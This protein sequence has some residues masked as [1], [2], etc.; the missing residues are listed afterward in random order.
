MPSTVNVHKAKANF[1]SVMGECVMRRNRVIFTL[2]ALCAALIAQGV[3]TQPPIDGARKKCISFGWEYGYLTPAQL[4]ANAEKFKGTAIDGVGIYLM[5]TNRAGQQIGTRNFTSGPEWD[6]EAFADQI[7]TL[8]K[9]AQTDHLRESFLKCFDAPRKRLAWTDD[10]AWARV[11]RNMGIVG[12]ISRAT[13]IKG[14]NSD[15]EDYYNQKQYQPIPGEPPY[16]EL[17]KIVR[18]RGRE[19]FGPLFREQPE[20]RVLFYW[21][22]TFDKT[23]FAVPDPRALAREKQ[24]LWPAFAD[25]IMDVLPPTARI[26]DGDEHAYNS[27]YATRDFHVSVC[28]QRQFAPR[29]LSPENRQK[30]ATQVQVGFG[31]YLDM[32]VNPGPAWYMGPVAGSRVEHFRRNYADAFKLAD[33]YVWLWGER[34]PTVHW[35]NATIN[36]SVKEK[37]TW[38]EALPGLYQPMLA[39]HDAD[40]GFRRRKDELAAKGTL[41]DL[42]SNP[43][44]RPDAESAKGKLPTPY[45]I[46]AGKGKPVFRLAEGQGDGDRHCL[47]VSGS[48]TGA[49]L[50][51]FNN[52][53]VGAAYAVSCRMKGG[54]PK[55][56][57]GWR[58]SENKWLWGLGTIR[59][60]FSPPDASGWRSG[61]AFVN[62]PMG[63]A[64]FAFVFDPKMADGETVLIDNAH[65]WELW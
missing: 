57:V 3:P 47:S 1:S 41:K 43:E 42:N 37:R 6:F 20:A 16:D 44:C 32:Y 59:L 22:L 14:F 29:L 40:Y 25:G 30:H 52:A 27:D 65:V 12:R 64:G 55:A 50:L 24:D 4:L 15:P 31:L 13:G 54:D 46:Y 9:I 38:A 10:A 5:A 48:K 21:F 28:N 18:R 34:L 36:P 23:Y 49:I 51:E 17:V 58:S 45:K 2:T 63:A 11:G 61:E 56:Y 19:V 33:E 8:K 39:L 35:E 7:P 53:S 26:V 60:T 62:V